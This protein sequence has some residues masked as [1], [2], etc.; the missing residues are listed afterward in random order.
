MAGANGIWA[1][2]CTEGASIGN[3]SS[4]VTIINL[5]RLGN[6]KVLKMYN[7]SYLR[8]AAIRVTEITTGSPPH[9]NQPIFGSRATDFMLDLKPED[10]DLAS[11]FG[12]KAPVRIT[13]LASP[14][15]ILSRLSELFGNSTAFTLEIASK[16]KEMIWGG[17]SERK[18]VMNF[19]AYSNTSISFARSTKT[20]GN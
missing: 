13:S 14:Q 10:F 3:A 19:S 20:P 4:C 9:K 12:E 2:V 17:S 18:V 6:K 16:M 15:M 1:S 5:V 8:K 11:F 7:C